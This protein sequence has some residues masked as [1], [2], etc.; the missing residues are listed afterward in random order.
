MAFCQVQPLKQQGGNTTYL[1]EEGGG[2]IAREDTCY[3]V[4]LNGIAFG[5]QQVSSEETLS[6]F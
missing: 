1:K 3:I 5:F 2:W 6:Y 4:T